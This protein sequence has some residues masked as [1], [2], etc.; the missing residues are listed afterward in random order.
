MCMNLN[1]FCSKHLMTSLYH[2][3]HAS[4]LDSSDDARCKLHRIFPKI[5]SPRIQ[6]VLHLQ[7]MVTAYCGFMHFIRPV[8]SGWSII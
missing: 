2:L 1:Q 3:L 8:K 7:T 5:H 4:Q 6:T